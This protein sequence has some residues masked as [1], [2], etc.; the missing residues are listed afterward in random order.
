MQLLVHIN[1]H[2]ESM[3]PLLAA[4]MEA[5]VQGATV[6]DCKGMLTA[7]DESNVEPPPIFGSLRHF[8]NP[9]HQN[10]KMFFMVLKDEDVAKVRDIIHRVAGNLRLPN[11]GILFTMPVMNWE[12]V[13]HS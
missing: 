10:G 7:L 1:N 9:S 12:G 4:L 6:V 5:G 8:I 3:T 2:V 13:K 11:T